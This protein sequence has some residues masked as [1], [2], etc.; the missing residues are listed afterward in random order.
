MTEDMSILFKIELLKDCEHG[1]KGEIVIKNAD[2]SD[3]LVKGGY[4]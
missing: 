1:K 2:I 4:W 3:D